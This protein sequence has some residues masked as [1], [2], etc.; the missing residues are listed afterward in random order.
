MKLSSNFDALNFVSIMQFRKLE[1]VNKLS[2]NALKNLD[3]LTK[4]AISKTLIQL[5]NIR[6]AEFIT[7]TKVNEKYNPNESHAQ[8]SKMY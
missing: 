8:I 7:H 2:L 5:A 6:D 4:I 3:H 1:F